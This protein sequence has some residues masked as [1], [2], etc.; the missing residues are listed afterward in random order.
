MPLARPAV[1]LVAV[2]ALAA[3]A[4]ASV[5]AAVPA[6]I[7]NRVKTYKQV[8]AFVRP[9]PPID[10]S[11]ARGK[12]IFIIPESSSIPF[13]STIDKSIEKVARLVGVKTV[14][15]TNQAQPSEW[16]AGINQAIA[17]KPDLIM[18]QGA[19][20][21]RVLQPQLLAA[22]RAG[23][24]V[25]VTH[26][27]EE[28][29]PMP[30]NVTALVRVQ[31]NQAARLEADYTITDTGGKANVLI[32][33]SNEVPIA[34]GMLNAMKQEFAKCGSACKYTIVNVPI[35][36]WATKIQTEVQS[37]L[38][39][40]PEI[41]YVIPFVDGMAQ[42]TVAGITAAGKVGK[43]K[44]AT[45][46]GTPFALKLIQ[47]GNVVAMDV[48]ENLDWLGWADMDQALRILVG[49][50][51]VRSEHTPLRLFD[52]SNVAQAGTPPRDSTGYGHAYVDRY[53]EL[54]GLK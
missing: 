31:F 41:N 20:D 52:R 35:P 53:K 30:P 38:V 17:R 48:G 16:A 28:S 5:S 22:K 25:L 21:P 23:I 24:P 26:F 12:T 49:A 6:E 47:D 27:F 37:A 8:P 4:V 19:P 29:D 10:A 44:V 42:F 18:L 2:A 34:K 43:V 15:Y 40:N 9:G 51:P 33:T 50:K 1:S 36:D 46:N 32:V 13:I 3:I 14:V 7:A 45:F 11:K 54:W 39:R